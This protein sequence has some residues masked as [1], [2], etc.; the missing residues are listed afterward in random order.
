MQPTFSPALGR[1]VLFA[2][3]LASS[4][5]FIDSTALNVALPA[6]QADL[7]ASG[8]DL[9]WI[10]N[11]YALLLAALLLVG[12]A[13]GDR[14]GRRRVFMAGIGLFAAASLLCG[15]AP[16]TG[17][18][19][20]AR[21]LQ[22]VGGALMVPGSLA[23]LAAL[24][25]AERRGQAV[26]TWSSFSTI[27]TML[28]P[29]LG[30]LLAQAGLWRA[31][32]L[33]NLPLAA[34]ALWALWRH[35]PESR[36]PAAG[37]LDYPGAALATLGLSGL[38]YGCIEAA[39]RGFGAPD[40][41]AALLGGAAALAAF[42]AV[43]AR[44]AHPMVPLSLFR[45]RSFSGT[46]AMTLFLYAALSGALFF[47]PL[48]LV[49]AQGYDAGLVGLVLLPFSLLLAGL[50]R[51]AGALA[52]RL[53]PRLPL[54]VGPALAGLGFGLYA[55]PGLTG[56]PRDYWTTFFPATLVLGLG[57]AC[58]VAPLSATVIGAAP[59]ERA[60]VASGISNAVSRAAGVLAVALLGALALLVFRAALE[61][62]AA[63]LGLPAPARAALLAA[64]A[65]LG[66]TRPPP[67]LPAETAAAAR[68]A[69]RLAFVDSFRAVMLAASG[70]AGL[71]ALTSALLIERKT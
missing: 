70:L 60:G 27:T 28:G 1:W 44:A 57:M 8:P 3:I 68:L 69:V 19:I 61:G 46:N 66:E 39:R 14:L 37:P 22:G 15:L 34:L 13:L 23:L 65:D 7:G 4:M 52:D 54:T 25:P 63:E 62:R 24:F 11:A 12:G 17:L 26:G 47:L 55:L 35:V 21:A 58:T 40:V 29:A 51:W 32:F 59:P 50:S 64:S 43:E 71:A 10:V 41:L 16:S 38:T 56:G 42:G 49:Q 9:L 5:A 30:G 45:S 67:G 48:N 20:G 31:V 18:L 33:I 36:D 2:T 53:G 6:L